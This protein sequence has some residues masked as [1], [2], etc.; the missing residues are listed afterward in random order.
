PGGNDPGDEGPGDDGP[1]DDPDNDN[2]EPLPEDDVEPGVTVLDNLAKAIELLARNARTGSESSSRTKLHE[3]DTFDGTDPKKLRAFLIQCKLNFRDRPR[4]FRSDQAKVTFVQ[5]FL[6][7]MA[8]E[9]FELDLLGTEDPEDRPYWMDS[10]KEFVI[11][12]Q[13]TFGPHDLVADAESQLDHLQMKDNHQVNK[14]VVEFNRL[15]SQVRGYGDGALHHFFYT[16]LPDRIKDEVCQVGKPRTLHELCHLVQEIDARYW[17]R[18]EE[19]QQSSKHQGSSSGNKSTPN[20]GHNNQSKPGQ[21]SLNLGLC[22]RGKKIGSSSQDSAQT[23]SCVDSSCAPSE[24]CLNT[25]TLSNPNSLTPHVSIVSHEL[26]R[27]RT[28]VDSGSMHS[29]IDKD[30][31]NRHS[32][33]PYPVSPIQLRLF[34]GSSS[35]VITQAVDLS[36]QFATSN[37]TLVTLFLA[38]LDSECKIV[39]GHDWLTHYNP[40]IDWV[41]SSLTFWTSTG[42]MP[43]PSTPPATPVLTG[44]PKSGLTDQPNP[45]PAPSVPSVDSLV[46]TPLK[47]PPITLI[48]AA[49]YVRA[50]KLEGSTQFQLHLC[51]LD[52]VLAR[53]TSTSPPPDLAGVPKDY[54]NFADVFSKAK[55]ST[56]PPHWEYDLKI[57]LEEGTTPPVGT[58]YSLS[59]VELQALQA[60]ID[61]NLTTGFIRPTSSPYAAPVLFIKKK[62]GSLRLC[63]DFWGLNKLT[64]KDRYPLPLIS[65]LLDSPSHAKIYTKIDLRHAYHLVRIAPRDEWKTAFRTRYGSYEWLV[66]PFGLT[67]APA[68]FQRFVNSIF[69]DM[70]DVCI[71]VYLDDILIYS[72]DESSHKQHVREVLRWLR[73]HGLYAKPEKCEF[74]SDSVEYLG[75]HLSLAGLTMSSEKVKAICDWP[76]PRKVKDIQSFLGF[77]N[78]YRQFIFNYSDIVVPLTRLTCKGAPWNFSEECRRS[79]NKLKQAF[80]TAPVLTHFSPEAPITVETDASDYAIAGILS[81]TGGDGQIRPIAFYSCTLTA[82]ELN[83]DTH[84]KELLVIFEAFRT[85]QHYLEGSAVPVDIVTD[86][87]NLEYFSTSKVLTRH[88]ARWSEFLSQFNMVIRFRPGKLGA[89][90]DAL[91]RRWDVYPKEGDSD[92]ARVNPQNLRLVFTQEQLATSL[93]ATYLEYPVLHAVALMDVEKLHNDILSALPSDPVTQVRFSDTSDSQWSVDDA[94]FLRLDGRIYVPD[95]NDLRLRVLRF[96]HDHPL[97]GHFGQN[98]TLELIRHEYTW[99]GLRTFV[100][101]YVR[102]LCT[103]CARAKVPCHRPYG[104]LKQLPMPEKPWNSISMDFI[105]QLP[106]STGFTAILVVVNR[107][108]KQ[109]IFIPTHDTI[110]APELAK[111]FLMHVFSKHGVLAHVTSDWGSEFVSHFF[112]SLGKALDMRLHFTSRYH[113]EGDG[114][115]ECTNQTLEQY[116]RVYCNYQQDNW[117]E[118]LPLAEFAYNNA[119]SAMT[120][121]SPFFANKGY[122]P[123]ISVFP[124]HD[125]TSNRAR[126]YAVDLD[127]LHQYLREEMA[128]AQ[129]RYQGPADAKR[130]PAPDF[131][132]G[133]NVYVKARYFRST[134][135]SKKLSEKNLG[136]YPIIAQ[137]GSHSFTLHL[138][139]SMRAVHPVFHVSQLEPAIPNTIPN[140][141]QPPPPPVDVNGNLEFE[142]A[143]ILDSKVDWRRRCW[144]QYLVRWTGYEGTDEET[145]WVLA[146]ELD[147]VSELVQEYHDRYPHKPSP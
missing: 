33:A 106:A 21:E 93:R 144:L 41:L 34:D 94:S 45:G 25:S 77:A 135:P 39:L 127:S 138:P 50:C 67:N 72:G 38:P 64:K 6:K 66:M 96:K 79:F 4:A 115:T 147:N 98:R 69:A 120:G 108:S 80:T 82:P 49:A 70:L 124:E 56:L 78:F 84:D 27:F 12:L 55:A 136:P 110:T 14:Y 10:W 19:V 5:S 76:E 20:P 134:R 1:G 47:A 51:P 117:A 35:F 31:V 9:W 109:A 42:G 61:E 123:N 58:I 143:E 121:V 133:N 132:V 131:K 85:W 8:L 100:K 32:F 113:P 54:H 30:F 141:S 91:T 65:D 40:S 73:L 139:D 87:K 15:A 63:V 26:P 111:L 116:L 28:L 99:P 129:Q 24:A 46:H 2:E 29:F 7:G 107:L 92:Y 53:S 103:T 112:R 43:T 137:A 105:E 128:L 104:L 74:H 86:H 17:E 23:E 37:V 22:P 114:Q 83:Y 88:Q 102:S 90:P 18:K 68:A 3:P 59:P 60:F 44:L 126:D 130:M 145:T 146:T 101:D 52:P 36:V 57:E 71:V 62:D 13:T 89:K 16:G 95:S 75:Y 119:P 125:L 11:E 118:L 48:N 81:I 122:H 140:Q 142:V 97:S